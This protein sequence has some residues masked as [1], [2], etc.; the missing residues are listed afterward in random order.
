MFVK[1]QTL[2]QTE[3][4]MTTTNTNDFKIKLSFGKKVV[5]LNSD[6][7][8]IDIYDEGGE[9]VNLV[10]NDGYTSGYDK[11]KTINGWELVYKF[12]EPGKVLF[13]GKLEISYFLSGWA[14][15]EGKI[16]SIG[17]IR[18]SYYGD[19]WDSSLQGKLHLVNDIF[20][21]YYDSSWGAK[22]G[23][24]HS[25]DGVDKTVSVVRLR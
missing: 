4:Q 20:L 21:T 15:L 24:L 17:E 19:G 9:P 16:Q 12:N 1:S 18:L 2:T 8:I 7:Q 14:A 11:L 3:I 23:I 22:K 25:I 13:I 6:G 5:L 10:Y